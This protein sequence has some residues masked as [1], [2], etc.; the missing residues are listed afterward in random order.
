SIA[1]TTITL[2]FYSNSSVDPSG[3]GEGQIYLGSTTVTTDGSGN[4]TFNATVAA[5]SSGQSITATA[6]DPA[7]NTS[8]FSLAQG[9]AATIIGAPASSP[10]GTAISLTSSFVD[11]NAGS[12]SF[13][14]SVT[15][16]GQVFNP[17]TPVN[18]TTFTF[19]PDDNGTYVVT[20]TVTN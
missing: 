16:N 1:S 9:L 3:Y 11:P 13:L 7:G 6:T 20:F 10:E 17:G 12:H 4:A 2:D 5:S 8:E 14:W 18:Q 15:K 19:T